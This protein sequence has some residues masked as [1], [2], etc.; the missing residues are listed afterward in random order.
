VK[1]AFDAIKWRRI[2]QR[3]TF[4][5]PASILLVYTLAGFFLAPW[6]IRH[7]LPQII[8]DNLH[9][10]T[11]LGKVRVNPYLFKLQINNIR[12]VA[13]DGEPI[14]ACGRLLADWEAKSLFKWAWVFREVRLEAP[15][16][17]AVIDQKGGLNLAGLGAPST[18]AQPTDPTP[19]QP[20]RL[21]FE[22]IQIVNGHLTFTDQRPGQPATLT[23]APIDAAF[24]RLTTLPAQEGAV[25]V[26]AVS[27]HHETVT[28]EGRVGLNPLTL[29]G[30]LN[31]QNVRS[32]TLAAFAGDRLHLAPPAGTLAGESDCLFDLGPNAARFELSNLSLLLSG[33]ALAL[34]DAPKPFLELPEVRLSGARLDLGGRKV[35]LGSIAVQGGSA[36]LAIDEK[37]V[38]NLQRVPVPA[39]KHSEKSVPPS[40][41]Q[42]SS[43]A[44]T[45]QLGELKID[46][47]N[48]QYQDRRRNPDLEVAVGNIQARLTAV[49]NTGKR[50]SA[51]VK[52][53][54]LRLS[55][56]QA[57]FADAPPA[58]RIGSAT[59]EKGDADLEKKRFKAARI[60]VEGGDIQLERRME[61]RLNLA[62]LFGPAQ[63][64]A[65]AQPPVA[66]EGKPEADP[67]PT[68]QFLVDRISLSGIQ[69]TVWD[70]KVLD[71]RPLLTVDSLSAA[72]AQVDGRSPMPVELAF[73]VREGGQIKVAGTLDPAAGAVS[74]RI[75][76]SSLALATFQPYIAGAAKVILKS[77]TL[78]TAGTLSHGVQAA[79]AQTAYQGG[80][81]VENLQVVEPDSDETVI[82]WNQAST[83]QL[84]L[85]AQPNTLEIGDLHIKALSGKA[86]IEK[87]GSFNLANLF[88]KE[89]SGKPDGPEPAASQSAPAAERFDYRIRRILVNNGRISFADRRLWIPFD[90]KI[91]ELRGSIAGISSVQDARS[92]L[93]LRGRVDEFGTARAEG[94]V[95]SS[96]PKA[97]ANIKVAFRNLEMSKLT[98]YSGHFAG[99]TID[100][101]KLAVDLDYTVD[102]GRLK[103][104]NEII[105]EQLKLGEKVESP[106]A[107]DLPLDLAVALL[108]D[109]KGV[110]DLG[111]PVQG[112]LNSPE[113]SF[114]ALVGKALANLLKKVAT[115]P[116]RALGALGPGGEE[117]T[118]DR[119]AFDSGRANVPPPEKEKLLKLA[120]ALRQRPQVKLLVQGRYH[121]QKDRHS[122]AR[123][124]LRK[125]VTIRLG[126]SVASDDAP[127]P[128]DFSSSETRDVLEAMFEEQFGED[129][130]EAFEDEMK[131]AAK[132]NQTADAG[133]YAKELFARLLTVQ[134]V[135]DER[136]VELAQARAQAVTAELAAQ[137]LPAERVGTLEPVA[138]EA[139]SADVTVALSMAARE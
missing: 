31:L 107:L 58:I 68:L 123:R 111:L 110:I 7:C 92:E 119:V 117:E 127:I 49:A 37:G 76:V 34:P 21:I 59:L 29:K 69:A 66:V 116:F 30:H 24:N 14:I 137:G 16:V 52:E 134:P 41:K 27:T 100:A 103:G 10:E 61:G 12:M 101:G 20:P 2:V 85:L 91:H 90:T 83:E 63:E 53:I 47:F 122:L 136:L 57:G 71:D 72:A 51:H 112:D 102:N 79:G 43:P 70:R 1:I 36:R 113:F 73:G 129:A 125:T 121:P 17:R 55:D 23:L 13:A 94:E 74:A 6:L 42:K 104:N 8:Q 18:A 39:G 50:R 60:A 138:L 131:A 81:K 130:L 44:W 4:I 3:K 38:F 77:G 114:G 67:S 33:I 9:L 75:E 88:K 26:T 32:A 128:L 48:A 45:F 93:R 56:L 40:T 120:E 95:N 139:A 106:D 118:L 15:E 135:P 89:S 82:G 28:W 87:D 54:A 5:I 78:S 109:S 11:Q 86:I 35:D 98:P 99:R 46:G 25:S 97:F 126:Q 62:R 22:N 64:E 84:K 115:S 19:E 80:F 132:E 133:F 65:A 96:N 108:K 105:V 124:S